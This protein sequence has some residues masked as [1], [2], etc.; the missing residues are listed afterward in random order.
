MLIDNI[1]YFL[2]IGIIFTVPFLLFCRWASGSWLSPLVIKGVYV[3]M[4]GCFMGLIRFDETNFALTCSFGFLLYL[5]GLLWAWRKSAPDFLREAHLFPPITSPASFN[6][7]AVAVMVMLI[8]VNILFIPAILRSGFSLDVIANFR[9]SV[10]AEAKWPFLIYMAI[11]SASLF[12]LAVVRRGPILWAGILV[13]TYTLVPTVLLGSKGAVMVLV[14]DLITVYYLRGIFAPLVAGEPAPSI[15]TRLGLYGL[16]A[17]FISRDGAAKPERRLLSGLFILL[18]LAALVILL[19][20]PQAMVL[21]GMAET[22]REANQVAFNRVLGSFDSVFF[23]VDS[24]LPPFAAGFVLIDWWLAAPLKVLGLF[25]QPFNA[26]NEYVM[27]HFYDQDNIV[28]MFPN[29]FQVV[30]VALTLPAALSPIFMFLSGY[31]MGYGLTW[32]GRR[33]FANPG[34]AL[35]FVVLGTNPYAMLIDGQSFWTS[36]IIVSVCIG[37]ALL[38]G[39]LIHRSGARTHGPLARSARHLP[40]T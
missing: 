36:I 5:S 24:K 38:I 6:T 16:A 12:P 3:G 14:L 26:A 22:Y 7:M 2:A 30:E 1:N 35:A 19:V 33:R 18:I 28:G 9:F 20:G 40:L 31:I 37:V 39:E 15:F 11:K 25:D 34:W 21:M 4:G 27:A 29:N 23:A 13:Y 8:I 17:F 10:R 32:L